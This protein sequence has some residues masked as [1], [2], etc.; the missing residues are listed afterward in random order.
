[1]SLHSALRR[2]GLF[3]QFDMTENNPM[4]R[5]SDVLK[6]HPEYFMDSTLPRLF[7]KV[8]DYQPDHPAAVSCGQSLTYREMDE[9]SSRVAHKLISER[10]RPGSAIAVMCGRSA[11]TI[12]AYFGVWKAGCTVVFL[13]R[14]YPSMRNRECMEECNAAEVITPE[15]IREAETEEPIAPEEDLSQPDQIAEIVYTSGSTSR[16]KGVLLSH[17]NILASASNYHLFRITSDDH[18]CCFASMMFVASVYD[19]A[20]SMA[21]GAVLYLIP[22][23]IRRSISDIAAYYRENGITIT[24]LPPHMARKYEALNEDSPLR[25]LIVG[26][27]PAHYLKPA[28]YQIAHVYASTE[29]CGVISIH[30]IR[31]EQETYPAGT[32]VPTLHWL[33]ADEQGREVKPGETGELLLAGPQICRGYLDLPLK[34]HNTFAAN[35]YSSD[36]KYRRMYRTGDLM[37]VNEDGELQFHGRMDAMV[38]VRGFRIELSA[39]ESYLRKFP[40]IQEA[41]C[42]VFEDKGGENILIGYYTADSDIDHTQLRTWMGKNLPYYMMPTALIHLDQMPRNTNSKIDR[43][44]LQAPAELNDHK[45]LAKLYY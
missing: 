26:S 23:E 21:T 40:G 3:I 10:I 42:K 15:W 2:C 43:R 14:E 18:Y 35:P 9:L 13:D 5:W 16:P 39:V 27:E 36:P 24:F 30:W 34:N 38:K 33:I 31:E 37:S 17:R 1:M 11:E 4:K 45:L 32:V 25:V 19:C 28:S 44:A 12:A 20:T 8:A 7:R 22:K 41:V 29:C 6:D